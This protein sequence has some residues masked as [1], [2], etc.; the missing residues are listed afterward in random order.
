[1]PVVLVMLDLF[2]FFVVLRRGGAT[3]CA[4]PTADLWGEAMKAS[5]KANARPDKTSSVTFG[6][7]NSKKR[8]RSSKAKSQAD[9]TSM[10]P[11]TVFEIFIDH[12]GKPSRT[13]HSSDGRVPVAG[14]VLNV[15]CV[16]YPK[17][18]P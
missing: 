16:R 15:C 4:T 12:K 6:R 2:R 14:T 3:V 5:D 13:T 9:A 7:D 1:M 11:L 10:V 8:P 17:R 18:A